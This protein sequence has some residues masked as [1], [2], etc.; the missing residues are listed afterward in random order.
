MGHSD[1]H[2]QYGTS[3]LGTLKL[4]IISGLTRSDFRLLQLIDFPVTHKIG[5]DRSQSNCSGQRYIIEGCA[6]KILPGSANLHI[7]EDN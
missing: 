3:F 5:E 4:S 2:T 7:A 6:L 1:V